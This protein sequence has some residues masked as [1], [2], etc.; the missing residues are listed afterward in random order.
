MTS[1]REVPYKA[2]MLADKNNDTSDS[3]SASIFN[4]GDRLRL[5]VDSMNEGFGLLAP[6]FTILE[7]NHEAM[8]IDGRRREEVVGQSHWVAYQGSKMAEIG[9]LYQKAMRERV[10]LSLEHRYEWPDGRTSWLETRVFPTSDGCLAVFFRD[11]TERYLTNE[12]LRNSE[13]RFRAAV[14]AIEGVV[15]TNNAAGQMAGEQPGWSALT[16]QT[17]AEYHGYGWSQAI[18]PDDA[19]PTTEAWQASVRAQKPFEFEHRVRRHD[20]KWRLFAVRAIPVNNISGRIVEWVGVHRDI[21]DARSTELRMRQLAETIDEVLYI[22]EVDGN[23]FSFVSPAYERVWGESREDLNANPRSFLDNLHPD[24][25]HKVEAAISEQINGHDTDIVYRLKHRDGN[26]RVIHD[27][28]F[29][30][31]DHLTYGLRIVGLAADITEERR[32]QDLLARNAETF[33]TLVVSNP[34]GIYVVDANFRLAELSEGARKAFAGVDPLIGRDFAEIMRICWIEPFASE[35]IKHF[36]LT[37]ATGEPFV[38]VSTVE[39]RADRCE[40]EAYDWRIDRIVLPDGSFGVVC[41]FYDLSERNVLEASLRQA[42]DDKKLLTSEID[43]RVKNSLTI[44]GSLLA[45]QRRA[46]ASSDT[47]AALHEASTRVLAVARLHEGLH[48]SDHLGVIAFGS[49]LENLCR[50]IAASMQRTGVS[51]NVRTAV[52]DLPADTA[53]PL[54]LITNE[55]VTNAFKHGC[56]AGA[57]V[58]EVCLDDMGEAVRVSVSDNGIGIKDAAVLGEQ[59][60]SDSATT[61]SLGLRLVATLARQINATITL[62]QSGETPVFTVSVQKPKRS[63]RESS[64]DNW[65]I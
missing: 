30:T 37:L 54:A 17:R 33:T 23:H 41:Y 8:R 26:E 28:A 11:V 45:M 25:R 46:S 56:A 13:Q 62:P 59:F 64:V 52:L 51:M 47:Q 20:G 40:I 57:T 36:R 44:V 3:Q 43:H 29:V 38:S 6:D 65:R 14:S 1:Q 48:R 10:Q 7:L 5:V 53:L 24:D 39:L 60:P 34:F 15:W 19:H 35:V 21:T 22:R 50:D 12:A 63:K 27:R 31:R 9:L 32:V 55:L 2:N 42:L 4:Q 16:G 18:H 61:K 58:I 49:Y